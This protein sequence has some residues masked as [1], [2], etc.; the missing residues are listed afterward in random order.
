MAQ[1]GFN[2]IKTNKQTN[3]PV[4]T[5]LTFHIR[6]IFVGSEIALLYDCR[7]DTALLYDRRRSEIALTYD[8]AR[9]EITLLYDY[10][11]K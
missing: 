1:K 10:R 5:R 3:K 9:S 2:P 4:M 6:M 7:S 11:G 8:V